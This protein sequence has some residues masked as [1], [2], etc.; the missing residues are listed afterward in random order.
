MADEEFH[1]GLKRSWPRPASIGADSVLCEPRL[2]VT[3]TAAAV[4]H[5]EDIDQRADHR[6][7]DRERESPEHEVADVAIDRGSQLGIFE[8]QLDY[9]L[10]FF[11]EFQAEARN[12][13]FV[14]RGGLYAS[15]SASG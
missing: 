10:D 8:Q 3:G 2:P 7:N 1:E 9:A 12:L 4:R 11:A 6:V 13:G 15:S 14:P 5:G